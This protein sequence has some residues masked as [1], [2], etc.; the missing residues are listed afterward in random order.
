VVAAPAGFALVK[1]DFSQIEARLAAYLPGDA[2]DIAVYEREGLPPYKHH[3]DWD[4]HSALVHQ[5]FPDVRDRWEGMTGTER[6]LYRFHA[7]TV[8]YGTL[9][10]GGAPETAKT[11]TFCPCGDSEWSPPWT[12]CTGQPPTLELTTTRKRAIVDAWMSRHTAF[13][14]WRREL[15]RPFQGPHA[16]H[17]LTNAMGWKRWFCTPYG[18]ELEREIYAW[19]ISSVASVI[20][21]RAL[22]R[23]HEKGLSVLFDHHDALMVL[24][25]ESDVEGVK[26][27]MIECMTVPVPE[28]NGVSFPVDVGSGQNWGALH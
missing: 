28:L 3:P 26:A 1:G 24:C 20:K 14:N 7:K 5:C 17:C 19:S 16:T 6:E 8:R 4:I 2:L 9:M 10:Y 21:L 15:L 27:T 13:T 12:R 11:K 18:P 22:R 25:P 23:L